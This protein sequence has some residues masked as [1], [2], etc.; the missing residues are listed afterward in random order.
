MNPITILIA[1]DHPEMRVGLVT[2]LSNEADFQVIGEATNGRQAVAFASKVC[3]DIVMMDISM[4]LI[5]GLTATRQILETTPSTKVLV[6]SSHSDEA[7]V[8]RAKA[9]GAA[10]YL[11]KQTDVKHLPESIRRVHAG[12]PFIF[13]SGPILQPQS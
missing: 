9:S 3:P 6:L 10:G 13:P 5:D 2:L 11:I 4:P 8:E 7:Y 1:E 12:A